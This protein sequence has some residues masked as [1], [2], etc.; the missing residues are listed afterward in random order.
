[1]VEQKTEGEGGRRSEGER[2]RK[3]KSIKNKRKE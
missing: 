1:M 3:E 2:E